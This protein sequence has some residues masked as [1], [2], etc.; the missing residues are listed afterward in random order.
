VAIDLGTANTRLFAA[1][2]GIVAD[3]PSVVTIFPWTERSPPLD[4]KRPN[5][6]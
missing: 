4:E 2:Q 3:E 5:W 1:G 6:R